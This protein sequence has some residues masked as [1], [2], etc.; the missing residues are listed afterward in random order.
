[1]SNLTQSDILKE[2]VTCIQMKL[3]LVKYMTLVGFL[4]SCA[5]RFTAILISSILKVLL[6]W[7]H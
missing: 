3:L 5:M 7:T 6:I 4:N 2:V 1:M